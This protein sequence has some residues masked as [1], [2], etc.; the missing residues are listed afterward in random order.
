MAK[1]KKKKTSSKSS[2]SSSSKSNSSSKSSSTVS[3]NSNT[4]A[5]LKKGESFTD[6]ATGK[7]YKQGQDFNT[8]SYVSDTKSSS[9]SLQSLFT[10]TNNLKTG[11]RG[12]DVKDL[13]SY[14][15]GVGLYQGKIDGIFG[16]QTD[17]AVRQ[18]QGSSGVKSDGIV[19]P[20]TR[21][22]LESIQSGKQVSKDIMDQMEEEFD[23]GNPADNAALKELRQF[24]KEQ[25]DQGL[26]INPNLNFDEAT[27]AKF[28]EAAK[29]QV[30][31]FFQ[32]QIDVIKQKVARELP[33]LQS[34]YDR[35]IKEEESGFEQGLGTARENYAQEG[36]AFSGNR[37]RGE[38]GLEEAQNRNLQSLSESYGSK[39]GDLGRTAE[40]ELGTTNTDFSI[41]GIEQYSAS[42]QGRGGFQKGGKKE[43]FKSGTYKVGKI[44]QDREATIEA[45]NQALRKTAAEN[46][47][48]GRSYEDLFE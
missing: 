44:Q 42:R 7:T 16:P 29:K 12:D 41:P 46:V 34:D 43:F 14:L 33:S 11:S 37:A 26:K 22:A 32:Q 39:I 36:L 45:R 20:K 35:R 30:N 2:S 25:M 5:K 6:K 15:A 3:Y 27:L 23:T 17:K 8:K 21:A 48:Q 28:L 10:S 4:G 47:T 38:I 1:K 18:M 31:P 40:E 24:I 19:G 9:P 13:Q